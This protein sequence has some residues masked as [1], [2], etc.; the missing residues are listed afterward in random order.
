[1]TQAATL[2][3]RSVLSVVARSLSCCATAPLTA[4]SRA[5]VNCSGGRA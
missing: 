2:G 1:M 3:L 5:A 4:A